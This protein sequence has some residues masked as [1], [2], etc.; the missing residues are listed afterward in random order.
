MGAGLTAEQLNTMDHAALVAIILAQQS[1]LEMQTQLLKQQA[2]K[3]DLLS[4]QVEYLIE[5]VR[6]ANQLAGG[7]AQVVGHPVHDVICLRMYRAAVQRVLR[8]L[9]PQETGALLESLLAQTGHLH[10]L[11]AG[12]VAARLGAVSHDIVGQSGADAG[13]V[14]EQV[15]TR[16]VQ[17]H[18]HAVHAAFHGIVQLFVQERLVHVVLVLADSQGLRV[19]LDQFGERVHQAAADGNCA[20]DGHVFVRELL[21]RD[22]GR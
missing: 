6:I 10:E 1:Q 16:R 13:N 17:V 21:P 12:L 8:L 7:H 3:T 20:A 19:N 15:W 9:D 4:Q 14:L 11:P 22:I 5:Q 2:E 18:A